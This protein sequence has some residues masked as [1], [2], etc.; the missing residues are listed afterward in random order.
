MT[1]KEYLISQL[2]D[3]Y[4]EATSVQTQTAL[5]AYAIRMFK[6]TDGYSIDDAI[7]IIKKCGFD[8]EKFIK[9]CTDYLS[10]CTAFMTLKYRTPHLDD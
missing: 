5:S 3:P 8:D 1:A 10:N 9:H 6:G 4:V 7:G 2:S